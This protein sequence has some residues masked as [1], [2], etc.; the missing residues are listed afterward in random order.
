MEI[1]FYQNKRNKNKYL[2]VHHSTCGHYTVAQFMSFPNGVQN[3]MGVRNNKRKLH[4]WR[5][6]ELFVLLED[7]QEVKR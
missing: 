2:E 5:K 1:K 6:A 4:R 3:W 7:Y